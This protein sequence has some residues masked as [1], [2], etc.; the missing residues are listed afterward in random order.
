M[1]DDD[2]RELGQSER[3]SVFH[4]GLID[5]VGDDVDVDVG[6]EN[7]EEEGGGTLLLLLVFVC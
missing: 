4:E 5:D 7:E 3:K 1:D 2:G 6:E